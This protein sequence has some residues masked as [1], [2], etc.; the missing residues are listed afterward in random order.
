MTLVRNGSNDAMKASCG[1]G[2]EEAESDDG[3]CL[4]AAVCK[5][6][7]SRFDKLVQIGDTLMELSA[8]TADEPI[9]E[10]RHLA[11]QNGWA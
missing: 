5:V 9:A 7:V 2:G 3:W 10:W 6:R 8:D 4:E 1:K 11:E